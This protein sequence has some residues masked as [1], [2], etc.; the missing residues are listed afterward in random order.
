MIIMLGTPLSKP[1]T[2]IMK[3]ASLPYKKTGQNLIVI[4]LSKEM[5]AGEGEEGQVEAEVEEAEGMGMGMGM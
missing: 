1:S 3:M 4:T 2:L 5:M